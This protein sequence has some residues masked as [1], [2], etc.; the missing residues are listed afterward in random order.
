MKMIEQSDEILVKVPQ[1][2][3]VFICMKMILR[4]WFFSA[5]IGLILTIL[6]MAKYVENLLKD[7]SRIIRVSSRR[8]SADTG[9][10]YKTDHIPWS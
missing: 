7:S 5:D 4:L 8:G 6:T 10:H 1:Y 3:I 2:G 9:G